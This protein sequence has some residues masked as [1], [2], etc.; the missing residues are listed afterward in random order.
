M[1][2]SSGLE[3]V[4]AL[5]RLHVALDVVPAQALGLRRGGSR[6]RSRPSSPSRRS[7]R[8]P[9][10]GVALIEDLGAAHRALPLGIALEVHQRVEAR[11]GRRLDLHASLGAASR[12]IR[13][14]PARRQRSSG[15]ASTRVG[16]HA[17][18]PAARRRPPAGARAGRSRRRR[19]PPPPARRAR[20]AR[21]ANCSAS[22]GRARS[23]SYAA[24][25]RHHQLRPRGLHLGPLHGARLLARQAQ[26]VEPPA[27]SIICG[28]QWPAHEHRVQP[29][30]RRHRGARGA[31]APPRPPR[32]GGRPRPR[33]APLAGLVAPAASAS[34]GTSASTSPRV[35]GSSDSTSGRERSAPPRRARRRRRR[36]TP[37]TPPA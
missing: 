22:C 17:G 11:L 4:L 8:P 31:L 3:P 26:Q 1:P 16:V 20:P 12:A 10:T 34:R 23:V 30:E 13:A 2:P 14:G 15:G 7:R 9:R 19:P 25:H 37:R 33:P 27:S 28:T 18:G 24:G 6:A 36:R 29:L 35:V 5:D 21:S 32:P